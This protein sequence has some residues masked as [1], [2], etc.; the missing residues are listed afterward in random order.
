MRKND[1]AD[2]WNR[3]QRTRGCWLWKANTFSC[4]YGRFS[5]N[6]RTYV[7]HRLAWEVTYGA[8][9]KGLLV[10]HHCDNKRC[11]NPKHLFLGTQKDNIQDALKK[12]RMATGERSG[13]HTHPEKRPRGEGHYCSK[14][15]WKAVRRIRALCATGKYTMRQLADRYGVTEGAIRHIVHN[16]NWK[17]TK[18]C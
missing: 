13:A 9:P 15:K 2:F 10:C 12:G 5:M 8:I 4:G 1:V 18:A 6:G 17:E 3:V 14:L 11:V 16:R 7:A